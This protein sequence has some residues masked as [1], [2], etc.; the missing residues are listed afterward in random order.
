MT[1]G[2]LRA[3]CLYNGISSGPNARYRVWEAFTF[4]LPFSVAM[5]CLFHARHKMP[6]LKGTKISVKAQKI[7][8]RLRRTHIVDGAFK[9]WLYAICFFHMCN[10]V[11]F[12]INRL[13]FTCASWK[14]LNN[15]EF[16]KLINTV[17]V[18][19]LTYN[20]ITV[21]ILS[22]DSMLYTQTLQRKTPNTEY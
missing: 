6:I 20:I 3:D 4:T 21:T 10:S 9:W 7:P 19:N 18:I 14:V 11:M 22:R 13:I 8:S 16:K 2:H 15:K 1:Y 17:F 5:C 12:C